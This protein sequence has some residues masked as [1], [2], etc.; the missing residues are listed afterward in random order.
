MKTPIFY[1][2][3]VLDNND[4]LML[5]R[6]R[7]VRLIDNYSDIIKSITS[8]VWND[9]K[10]PWTERD[11]FIFNPLLPYYVY[12]VPKEDEMVQVMYLN[13]EFIYQN[14]Y[15]IQN[16][17]S[18]PT[19]TKKEY[20]YGANALTG[21]GMRVKPSVPLKNK[22]GTYTNKEVHKGVFPE[23]GDNALLGRGSADLVVKE[24]EV[25][26]RAGKFTNNE[27]QTNVLPTRND[28]RSFLQLSRFSNQVNK[29]PDVEIVQSEE[30]ILQ[31]KYLI[32][33][34]ITN[35][36]NELN[37]FSGNVYLYKLKQD[38]TTNSSNISVS[39]NVSENL[40]ILVDSIQFINQPKTTVIEI[41]N[42]Y[43]KS[44]NDRNITESGIQIELN[45]G[46]KF[47]IYYRPNAYTYGMMSPSGL[48]STPITIKNISD[49]F[50][51]IKLN[52]T[53]KIGGYGL[54]YSKNLVGTP[55]DSKI[56]K[57]PQSKLNRSP[58]TVGALGADNLYL[59]SHKSSIP[60]KGKINFDGTLY[61]ISQDKIASE[62]D[63]KT[64]SSVR[65]EELL[66]LL[67]II[68]RFLVTHT[69]AY[70]GLPPVPVTQDGSKLS[71][72]LTEMQNAYQK[73][74]NSNIRLN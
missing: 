43:I 1:Q 35:P 7:G 74:L 49:I 52:S 39:S 31:V 44:I 21:T 10:D 17:Y 15:Y 62:L 30:K 33:W 42:D 18:S 22:N 70:P 50:S 53:L 38:I 34:V 59:L 73:I 66:E 64:S 54:I 72:L 3:K 28:G 51:Q 61:G 65:G 12:Q 13:N 48:N 26:L 58:L 41:I 63:P 11:P 2:V 14:Q 20:Y 19:S 60:G 27:L 55:L 57:L 25:L 56:T 68:V 23:P 24:D 45:D 47:P 16:T 6:I 5:G 40:K 69:H 4:P 8:P 36:E 37:L 71:D 9:E 29:L 32:E 46:D 67:S